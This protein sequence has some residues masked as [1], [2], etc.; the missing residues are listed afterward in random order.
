MEDIYVTNSI[1]NLGD[2]YKYSHASQYPNNMISMYSYMESRGGVYPATIFVGLQ[3]YLKAYLTTPITAEDIMNAVHKAAL[4]GIPFDRAGWEHILKEHKGFLPIR[5]KAVKEGSLVPTNHV[6]LTIESTDDTVPWIAGFVETLLMK[7]WYP[8]TVATKSYYVRKMLE[9]YGSSEWAK[10]AYHNFGDR[11]APS[12]EAAAIGGF[13]HLSQFM[14]TDNFNALNFCEEYYNVP[15]N[16]I[17][18]YSVFATEHSTTTSYGRDGEE[19]FVYNQLLANPDAPIMSFV[20]DSYDVYNFVH[21]CTDRGSRIRLLIESRPHQKFVIRPDSGNPIE[22]INRIMNIMKLNN[23]SILPTANG[24][25]LFKDFAILW[26]DGITPK[27]IEDILSINLT[28]GFAAEN[29]VFGSGGDLMQNVTR[30]TQKFAIKCSNITVEEKPGVHYVDAHGY[31]RYTYPK[32]KDIDVYKD[33]ITDPGKT[34]K[35]GKVTT[36]INTDTGAYVKGLRGT[37]PENCVEALIPVF[38]N[39]VILNTISLVDIRNNA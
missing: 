13:A 20:A 34:S 37:V 5:I 4:H 17:A 28:N 1:I 24:T 15:N 38:K 26:G 25:I 35:K 30:D 33:P 21:F 3:Y 32:L 7:I 36:Y 2:S 12:V 8:T 27:T 6:L 29:F 23:L 11:G 9:R 18:G 39:G 19:Q 14:G 16:E 31:D 22:V 10:F